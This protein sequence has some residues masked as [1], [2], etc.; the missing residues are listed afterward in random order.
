MSILSGQSSTL[1]WVVDNA[2]SQTITTLGSVVAAGTASV[3]PAATTTY[4]LTAT[5]AAGS[6]TATARVT[7]TQ[8]PN[9]NE[10]SFTANPNPSNTPGGAVVLNCQTQTA[11]SITMARLTFLTP[12]IT[13]TVYPQ[14]TTSYMCMATGENGVT[15][16]KALT[17]AVGSTIP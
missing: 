6:V 4:T 15:A 7:V 11:A 13:Y 12:N 8:I 2:T 17:V 16:Q 9:P 1:L 3:S 5:N 14:S 10:A